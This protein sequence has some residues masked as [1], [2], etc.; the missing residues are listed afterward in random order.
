MYK[1][2]RLGIVSY[3][4]LDIGLVRTKW[5]YWVFCEKTKSTYIS[6]PCFNPLLAGLTSVHILFLRPLQNA[7]LYLDGH[8][9]ISQ[10]EVVLW[11]TNSLNPGP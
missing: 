6:I 9:K 2:Y 3:L 10:E 5:K 1:L 8:L 11:S 7:V 4:S